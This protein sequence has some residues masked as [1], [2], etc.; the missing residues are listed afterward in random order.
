MKYIF[1]D[2]HVKITYSTLLNTN[3]MNN[4]ENYKE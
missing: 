4:Q 1:F 2:L 3:N